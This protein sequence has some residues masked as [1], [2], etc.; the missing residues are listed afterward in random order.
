MMARLLSDPLGSIHALGSAVF[1][2]LFAWQVSAQA[3]DQPG[4]VVSLGGSVTEIIYALGEQ[5]RILARDSTSSFP[6]GTQAL[7]DVGYVRALSPEG[8]LSVGPK[9]IIAEEGAGPAEAVDVLR[10]SSVT[11]VDVP[12]YHSPD[13]VVDKILLVGQALGVPDKAEAL[14]NDVSADLQNALNAVAARP[15]GRRRVLFVLST[16]G[17]RIMASG[18]NTAAH[19]IIELA[20]GENVVHS[21]TGYKPVTEE[22]IAVARPDVIL[23]MDRQ[24]GHGSSNA[25]LWKMPALAQTP[26]A[27]NDAVVRIDGLLLLGFGPRTPSAISTL[28]TALTEGS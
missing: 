27:L 5:D 22:A 21:F 2:A 4:D 10:K 13:G 7:P 26:A 18:A 19:A 23:M 28:H 8:V 17:G 6:P 25:D 3:A 11:F 1:C 12:D 9:L 24:G 20:G 16:Q 14:A 15:V